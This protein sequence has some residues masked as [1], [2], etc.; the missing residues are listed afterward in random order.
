MHELRRARARHPSVDAAPRSRAARSSSAR[1]SA[2]INFFDTAN[3]Y[4]DGTSEE[5]LGRALKDFA[6]PR[7]GGDRDQGLQPDARRAERRRPVAQG[8]PD[9]RS[10]TACAGSARTTSTSTRSTAGTTTRRSRRR[11]R[12][13]TTSSRRARP[14]TSAPRRCTPGS[15]R[16]R[17][18]LADRHGWT[19]F[20]SMQNHYNLLYREEEREM[21]PLCQA[22]GHRRHPVEP[23][24]ARPADSATGPRRTRLPAR[25]PTSSAAR[26]TARWRMPIEGSWRQ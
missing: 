9:A 25:R 15:S 5:I 19:R 21:M 7:R 3:V 13:F 18:T 11:S 4:S 2:G 10:T 17:C 22:E 12:R 6:P 8:H 24:G 16:R 23:A 1:W 20:V 14:A 26:S